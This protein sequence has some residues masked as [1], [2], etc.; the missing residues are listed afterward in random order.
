MKNKEG[1]TSGVRFPPAVILTYPLESSLFLI[2]APVGEVFRGR[3][4]VA[5]PLEPEAFPDGVP[6]FP[7][8]VMTEKRENFISLGLGLGGA[9]ALLG[10]GA[11]R[12]LRDAQGA[13]IP[14][15]GVK[16]V[17]FYGLLAPFTMAS[18]LTLCPRLSSW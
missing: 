6:V 17:P 7:V 12:A 14:V 18:A 10:L 16:R 9:V 13:R 8:A 1:K 4:A 15:S 11:A 3:R 2:L 5:S